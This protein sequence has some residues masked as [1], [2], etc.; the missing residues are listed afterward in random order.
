M[1]GVKSLLKQ[2]PRISSVANLHRNNSSIEHELIQGECVGHFKEVI[3]Q[4][5]APIF[6][7]SLCVENGTGMFHQQ[8]MVVNA[9]LC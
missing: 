3:V 7:Y 6:V 1:K 8:M 9:A 2:I 5:I 4:F